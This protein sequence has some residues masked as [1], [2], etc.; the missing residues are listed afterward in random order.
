MTKKTRKKTRSWLRK[1]E[2]KHDLDQENK[3]LIKKTRSWPRKQERKHDLDQEEES[4]VHDQ[5]K[6]SKF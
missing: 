6:K 4:K 2:R 1:Q 3:F 5:E